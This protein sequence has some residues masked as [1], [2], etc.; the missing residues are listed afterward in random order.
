MSL[1]DIV[2]ASQ[3]AIVKGYQLY[4]SKSYQE[5]VDA[6]KPVIEQLRPIQHE[7]PPFFLLYIHLAQA[8]Q[9]SSNAKYA[10]GETNEAIQDWQE[11][12]AVY[13]S[14]LAITADEV[15]R[16][17]AV[18]FNN[19]IDTKNVP[20]IISE[21]IATAAAYSFSLS[22]VLKEAGQVEAAIHYRKSARETYER[23]FAE[24]TH[25]IQASTLVPAALTFATMCLTDGR[26]GRAE[27]MYYLAAAAQTELAQ[28]DREL[29]R[30]GLRMVGQLAVMRN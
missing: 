1:V 17:F 27:R 5:A 12:L 28:V 2:L 10:L 3:D 7:Q 16:E 6:F 30:H 4:R 29:I 18:V 22:K 24:D 8:L 25:E 9:H 13:D 21:A 20:G 26:Y 14:A 15:E 19:T 23:L 11:M